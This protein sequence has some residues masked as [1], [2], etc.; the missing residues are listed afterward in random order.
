MKTTKRFNNRVNKSS[1]QLLPLLFAL[2]MCSPYI[3]SQVTIGSGYTPTRA[4]LLDIK[5]RQATTV[6]NTVGDDDNRTS[7]EGG[8][9]LPR[10]KLVSTNTLQ[11]FVAITDAEWT[12]A[13]KQ[14]AL[15]MS[16]AGL[17]VYNIASVGE[18]L[19][20]GLYTW[21]GEK[22]ATSQANPSAGMEISAQPKSFT[23]YELGTETVIP[24]EFVITGATS[25][26]TYQWY[27]VT[28]NN[29]HIRIGEPVTKGSG[30]KTATYTPTQVVKGTTRNANN[31]G[32]Y[33]FYCIA[34][35]SYGKSL[36]SDIAEVAVGC[37]AKNNAGE[38]IS[39]MCFNL[40]ADNNST[41]ESQKNYSISFTNEANGKHEYV[42]NEEDLFGDLFQWGRIPDGH[43]DRQSEVK[44]FGAFNSTHIVSG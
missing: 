44:A 34:T 17:M 16:V 33:K 10:V 36:E 18:S 6:I 20:P 28:G 4:A 14:K 5:T 27:Q 24:L 42:Q 30:M 12:D 21:D 7:D 22:W 3:R 2:L 15:R 31:T 40:G 37:G 23:F 39:F 26:V 11:P 41:I 29:V 1:R 13:T 35:D 43:E 8:I 9:L 32:F 25:T 19:Y 38:W